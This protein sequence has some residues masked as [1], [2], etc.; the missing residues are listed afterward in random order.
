MQ[1][2]KD[3][4]PDEGKKIDKISLQTDNRCVSINYFIATPCANRRSVVI[5]ELTA[6]SEPITCYDG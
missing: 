4:K 3:S 1:R 5:I 2:I 6:R